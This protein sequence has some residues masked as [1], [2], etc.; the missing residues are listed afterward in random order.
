MSVERE[1]VIITFENTDYTI[2]DCHI[3]ILDEDHCR[4]ETSDGEIGKILS[5]NWRNENGILPKFKIKWNG[6]HYV[7]QIHTTSVSPGFAVIEFTCLESA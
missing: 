1:N 6:Y 4:L 7:I 2:K 3:Q 5:R